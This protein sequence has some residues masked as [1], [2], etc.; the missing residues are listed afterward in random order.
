MNVIEKRRRLQREYD[1]EIQEKKLR[2]E[3][4]KK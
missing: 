3:R 1:R 4:E 2:E